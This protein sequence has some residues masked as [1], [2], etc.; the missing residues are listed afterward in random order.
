MRLLLVVETVENE[1][2]WNW[3]T[4]LIFSRVR[5]LPVEDMADCL[6]PPPMEKEITSSRLQ[7]IL[8]SPTLLQFL[9]RNSNFSLGRLLHPDRVIAIM[10][11][12][13][14]AQISPQIR[15]NL[16][17]FAQW[18]HLE[19]KDHDLEFVQT[20]SY[21]SLQILQQNG[22]N[23]HKRSFH[24]LARSAS[25]ICR[26]TLASESNSFHVYPR[27]VTEVCKIYSTRCKQCRQKYWAQIWRSKI[28]GDFLGAKTLGIKRVKFLVYSDSGGK[29][30]RV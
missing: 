23:G 13:R 11:G 20:V 27:R 2:L 3:Y 19:A 8:L 18:I 29:Y 10:L 1:W 28:Q 7:L 16:V 9:A 30:A 24:K 6:L 25:N 5:H 12:V 14:D 4:T 26:P 22:G 17:S 21:F 15:Q